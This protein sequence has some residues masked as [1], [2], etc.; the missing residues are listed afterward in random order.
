MRWL[1]H[2][3]PALAW[4]VLAWIFSTSVFSDQ[5]TSRFLIP[6][7]KWL[8]P[9]AAGSTLLLMH[10][11]VRKAA[12]IGEYFVLSVLLFRSI[13]GERSGWQLRWALFAFALAACY[14]V[15]D[16]GH[17]IF[18]PGRR[19]S[20]R[21]ALLDTSGAIMAQAVVWWHVARGSLAKFSRIV[22]PS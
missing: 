13:R 15:V 7:F 4:A 21:D 6:I 19:A 14:A 9:H 17:Q 5:H 16:E 8:F 3:G 10:K 2:W 18:V 12:H 1:R 20:V 11:A 22:S